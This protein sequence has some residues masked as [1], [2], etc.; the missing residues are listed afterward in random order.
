VSRVSDVQTHFGTTVTAPEFE[1]AAPAAYSAPAV[2]GLETLEIESETIVW[3]VVIIGF[4]FA[5]ALAYAAYC[6]SRGGHPSISFGWTGFKVSCS[7]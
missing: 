5:L 6:T 3:W 7:R 1:L 4:S 2:S